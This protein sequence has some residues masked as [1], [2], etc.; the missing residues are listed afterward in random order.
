MIQWRLDRPAIN[1]RVLVYYHDTHG[2]SMCVGW[3]DGQHWYKE[4]GTQHRDYTMIRGASI[5]WASLP[6][7]PD[8]TI[9]Y[10]R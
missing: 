8:N 2:W 1:A 6:N 7:L 9:L 5:A 4:L 10:N 3:Y